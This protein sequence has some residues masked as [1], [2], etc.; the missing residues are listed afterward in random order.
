MGTY[1]I[2]TYPFI[3]ILFF[4]KNVSV[5]ID[6]ETL[7]KLESD[8]IKKNA[9]TRITKQD[10]KKD[11]LTYLTSTS[12]ENTYTQSKKQKD[13]DNYRYITPYEAKKYIGKFKK[14]CGFV[15]QVKVKNNQAYLN[16]GGK[17]PNQKFVVYIN[18]LYKYDNIYNYSNKKVCVSGT[19]K[20]Y[21]SM[22]EI[23]NPYT[24]ELLE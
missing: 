11:N 5:T 4:I 6:R 21:N 22:P 24:L 16:F 20:D 12:N 19:I 10:E 2:D 13:T 17:Y 15:Y 14:I 23:I 9:K 7:K 1:H 3:L 8:V 18:K